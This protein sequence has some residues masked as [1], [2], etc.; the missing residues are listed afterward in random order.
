MH[1]FYVISQ[2]LTTELQSPPSSREFNNHLFHQK[3]GTLR[4]HVRGWNPHV[5]SNTHVFRW[6]L[7]VYTPLKR[8]VSDYKLFRSSDMR[9]LSEC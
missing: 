2:V 6:F 9:A 5:K 1:I 8:P 3:A 4:I 7:P